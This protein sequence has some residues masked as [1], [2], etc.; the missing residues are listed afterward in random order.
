MSLDQRLVEDYIYI[1]GPEDRLV[2]PEGNEVPFIPGEDLL[3]TGL[4]GPVWF[5]GGN[6]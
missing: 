1:L 4:L 5:F 3:R 6:G 2:D